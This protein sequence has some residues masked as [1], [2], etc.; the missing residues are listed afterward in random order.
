MGTVTLD[1][2]HLTNMPCPELQ[3]VMEE[4]LYTRVERISGCKRQVELIQCCFC[5]QRYLLLL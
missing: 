4:S 3:K 5:F 2:I 1:K